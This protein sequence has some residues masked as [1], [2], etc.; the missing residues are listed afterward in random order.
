MFVTGTREEFI[1]A[2]EGRLLQ[3]SFFPRP[4]NFFATLKPLDRK[5]IQ[6]HSIKSE[7]EKRAF[8]KSILK[9]VD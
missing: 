1:A 6:S 5:V 2:V 4:K 8:L 7:E 9:T 3:D